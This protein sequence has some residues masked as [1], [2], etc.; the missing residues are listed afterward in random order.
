MQPTFMANP[1]N[2]E[3]RWYVVDASGKPLGR[4]ASK[5]AAILRGKHRPEYTPHADIGDHVIVI[6]AAN[7]V[8]TGNK[9]ATKLYYRHSGYPGGMRKMVAGDMLRKK[10]EWVVERAVRGMLPHTTL[11][12]QMFK[13]LKVYSGDSHPHEAQK[14]EPLQI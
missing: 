13:K 1:Q 12:R 10:P 5:I 8:L 3:H 4:L 2:V 7:V 6:N 11:G 14:P 9:A